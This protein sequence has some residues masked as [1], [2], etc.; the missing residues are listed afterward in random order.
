[1]LWAEYRDFGE[2][3]RDGTLRDSPLMGELIQP[4]IGPHL[5]PGPPVVFGGCQL[6]PRPAPELGQH[7]DEVLGDLL[8]M[9]TAEV[10]RLRA[11][12]VVGE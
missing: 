10:A 3:V 7:T 8:S 4:G 9:S 11:Q 5:A 6:P 1:M 2:L 12:G